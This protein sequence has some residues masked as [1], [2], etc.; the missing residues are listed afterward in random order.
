M[1]R[2]LLIAAV[3]TAALLLLAVRVVLLVPSAEAGGGSTTFKIGVIDMERTLY[4]TPAGKRANEKFGKARKKKQKEIDKKQKELQKYAAELDKQATVLTPEK[5]AEKQKELEKKF[6]ALRDLAGKLEQDLV[7]EQTQLIENLL[8]E[9]K[10][11]VEKIAA[12]EGVSLIVN[13]G[14]VVWADESVDLTDDLAKK[15][16]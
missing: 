3:A 11:H 8:K 1:K 13:A 6:I 4:E 14:A 7:K 15:M 16:K 2:T 9:A 10:P 12:D 5:L